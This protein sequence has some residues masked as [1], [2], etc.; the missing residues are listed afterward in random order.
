MGA[1]NIFLGGTGKFIAEDIQSAR[2]F[3]QDWSIGEPAAFDLDPTIRPGVHLRGF[4]SADQQTIGGVAKLAS[5]WAKRD[6][7]RGL[8]PADGSGDPGPHIA[9]EQAPLAR[10]GEGIAANPTPT[11]GLFALRAHGL[12]VFSMMFDSRFAVAGAGPGHELRQHIKDRVSQETHGGA[13]PRINIVTSTAGG[14]GAGMVIPLALWL[15]EEY[16][17]SPLNLVAVTAS[18]FA[19]VLSGAPGLEETRAKGL[20]GTYALLREI[21]WFRDVDP[22]TRFSERRLPVTQ[23]GLAYRPGGELFD[24]IYWFGGRDGGSRDDAFREAEPLL[25]A[26][27][28]DQTAGDLRAVTGGSPLQ[29]V[30]AATAVEYPKLRLQRRMVYGVLRDAYRSLHEPA[31]KFAGES[32]ASESV[33]LLDYVGADTDRP[34]GAWLYARHDGSM[35]SQAVG[36]VTR[37]DASDLSG[38]V[39]QAA[40]LSSYNVPRGTNI[41][42][43]PYNSNDVGWKQYV[44]KVV[45]SLQVAGSANEGKLSAAVAKLRGDEEK[46]FDSWLRETV[47]GDWLSASGG[48]EPRATGEV[49][50]MLDA[51]E[52]EAGWYAKRFDPDDLFPVDSVE[53]ANKAVERQKEKFDKPDVP[54]ASATLRDKVLS[55]VVAGAVGVISAIVA[56]PVSEAIPSFAGGLSQWIPWI[57]VVALAIGAR[58]I[59]LGWL[60]RNR[61]KAA[62][63]EAVRLAAENKLIAAYGDRDHVRALRWLQQKLRG[64]GAQK[65]DPFFEALRQ[66]IASARVEVQRLD[67]IYKGLQ[68]RAA[69]EVSGGGER[70]AHVREEVGDCLADDPGMT[71]RIRPQVRRRIAI[72]P[73]GAGLLLRLRHA[74]PGDIGHFDPAGEDAVDLALALEAE[75]QAGLVDAAKARERWENAASGLVNWQLGEHLPADFHTAMLHCAN[76][77]AAM[78]LGSLTSKLQNLQLPK[79]PSVALVS[80]AGVPEHRRIYAGSNAILARLN[81]A[82][83]APSLTGAQKATLAE[84]QKNAMHVVPAL[85]EQIVFLDLWADPDGQPWAPNVIGNATEL[86]QAQATYYATAGTAP[87][88]TAASATF[89]VI[90]E[91][92]AATKIEMGGGTVHPL[93]SAVVARLLG[94]DLGMQGPTYAELFYLLRH[95]GLLRTIGEGAGPGARTVTVIGDGDDREAMRLVSRPVGAI[96]DAAFG[97][98]RAAVIDYDTFVEFMR[99]DGTPMMAGQDVGFSPFPNARPHVNDW[100]VH[101]SRVAAL[102]RMAVEE[103]YG[104]DVEDDADAMIEVLKGDVEAMKNG[105]AAVRAS[106]ERA[107]RRLLAGEERKAIR[108]AHLSAGA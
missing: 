66:R 77:D 103:W 40:G 7:G 45:G 6:P 61:V 73:A 17:N 60:L 28:A 106:W 1:V 15:R 48:G 49:L 93:A 108:R 51:L 75:N 105:D 80:S 68:D 43:D 24:R 71:E 55:L 88:T 11:A 89:T 92:L 100:A 101:T 63:K 37:E 8:G 13:A 87:D 14:T 33:S 18:A 72:E 36:G 4:V 90:P 91:L 107:M 22:Q 29:W 69:A 47:Y 78:A 94:C 59:T 74:D 34:L 53:E 21:S 5:D 70:P 41:A 82:L 44:A 12:A 95:R 86:Q 23:K 42:N 64:E 81:D 56:R 62:S 3:Y 85:G 30:G 10:I 2:D 9:P 19:N 26:L 52:S 104:G 16:P 83:N 20:S 76:N 54:D 50:E 32:V 39:R 65:Q 97:Q 46:A 27:S 67:G 25:R 35:A 38:A 102:Q 99:Y 31:G 96:A 84:Y 57:V 79:A 98:G 58:Q